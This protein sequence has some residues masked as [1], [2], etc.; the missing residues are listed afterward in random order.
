[1][2]LLCDGVYYSEQHQD[3][4]RIVEVCEKYCRVET[5]EL[6]EN[7]FTVWDDITNFPNTEMESMYEFIGV[8]RHDTLQS[9]NKKLT[10]LQV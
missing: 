9:L 6:E 8:L 3:C 2:K 5:I 4:V 10:L 7:S 1:M